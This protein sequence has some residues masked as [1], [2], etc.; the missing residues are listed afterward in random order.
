MSTQQ[1]AAVIV[2]TL[3][4]NSSRTAHLYPSNVGGRASSSHLVSLGTEASTAAYRAPLLARVHLRLG[5][6]SWTAEVRSAMLQLTDL[7]S[8]CL[9]QS[10]EPSHATM[11][12]DGW[13]CSLLALFRRPRTHCEHWWAPCR[14]A[15]CALRPA[16]VQRRL[17]LLKPYVCRFPTLPTLLT[18]FGRLS[19]MRCLAGVE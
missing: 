8:S 7:P 4:E 19:Y 11:I 18:C 6:W 16:W 9:G 5:L 1:S 13:V 2:S 12:E 15:P 17:G 3:R 14:T 10:S